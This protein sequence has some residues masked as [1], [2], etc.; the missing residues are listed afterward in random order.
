MSTHIGASREDISNIVLMPGDPMRAKMIAEKYLTNAK[1]VNTIR[2]M[3]GFT[4]YFQ[5]KRITVMASGMGNASMGIYS[6][7]LFN[8]YNVNYIIRIGT[9]GAYTDK[10][11]L[12][13]VLLVDKSF[14]DTSYGRN[15][16]YSLDN[17]SGSDTLNNII[18]ENAS[19]YCINIT[20]ANIH[21]TDAFYNDGYSK[22]LDLDCVGVE[23]E[24][25]AL[26]VNARRFAKQAATILTVSDN[27][28]TSES[29]SSIDRE[30]STIKMIE[31]ALVTALN[32]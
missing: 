11:K 24:S 29:M 32:L 31:L 28:V 5:N 26:F 16:G 18:M 21:N 13:D 7:E 4:G 27:L 22:F 10:L 8:D 12:N 6:Y 15:L 17:I 23:M 14:S 3:Y 20:K 9:C 2:G 25:F 30:K 19:K 1:V